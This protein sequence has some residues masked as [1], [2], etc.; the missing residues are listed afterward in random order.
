MTDADTLEE[1]LE[2][3][4]DAYVNCECECCT[5]WETWVYGTPHPGM[6]E[7]CKQLKVYHAADEALQKYKTT[8]QT[9]ERVTMD[10][11][12]T[13]WVKCSCADCKRFMAGVLIAD[14]PPPKTCPLWRTFDAAETAW[15]RSIELT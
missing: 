15:N 7:Q 11:A 2:E 6:V 13:A 1:T 4:Y 12:L 14:R 8:A 10:E 9:P 3:A 5:G